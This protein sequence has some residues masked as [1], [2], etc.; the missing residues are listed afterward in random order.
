MRIRKKINASVKALKFDPLDKVNSEFIE[1]DKLLSIYIEVYKQSKYS[2]KMK[3]EKMA[4]RLEKDTDADI[5]VERL[6]SISKDFKQL[7]ENPPFQDFAGPI[8]FS[9]ALVYSYM[10]GAN[11][12]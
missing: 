9:R 12:Y 1:V 11:S 4:M 5:T 7:K 2:Q 10:S 8:G 6:I 3:F